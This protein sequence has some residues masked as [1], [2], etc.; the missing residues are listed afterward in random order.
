MSG[1]SIF[2]RQKILALPVEIY[3]LIASYLSY[4]HLIAFSATNKT[5]RRVAYTVAQ[6]NYKK[7]YSSPLPNMSLTQL[8][9]YSIPHVSFI[10]KCVSHRIRS[11]LDAGLYYYD[12]KIPDQIPQDIVELCILKLNNEQRYN[13]TNGTLSITSFRL[14]LKTVLDMLAKGSELVD[15][16]TANFNNKYGFDLDIYTRFR[17]VKIYGHFLKTIL[18][19]PKAHL[20]RVFENFLLNIFY[21]SGGVVINTP[22]PDHV[23]KTCL[24]SHMDDKLDVCVCLR[25]IGNNDVSASMTHYY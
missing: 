8:L 20:N 3:I 2:N 6:D 12:Y 11:F 18:N 14:V 16:C 21:M 25:N 13:M 10:N 7:I 17:D 9:I 1:K 22:D 19:V 15:V 4:K 23:A 5:N 24:L